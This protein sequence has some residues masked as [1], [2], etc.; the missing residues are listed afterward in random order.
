MHASRRIFMGLAG[1]LGLVG[2][3]T[4]GLTAAASPARGFPAGEKPW[5]LSRSESFTLKWRDREFLI[6][7]ARPNDVDPDLPL[8]LGGYKPVPVYVTDGNEN[9]PIVAAIT[10]QMQWGGEVPPCLV[11][12]VDY[13]DSERAY[14]EDWRTREL[15]PTKDPRGLPRDAHGEFGGA[16][17]FRRFLVETLRPMIERRF[18]V[19][20]SRS[21]LVGHSFGGLFTLDTMLEEPAAFGNYLAMSP[22][23]WFDDNVV[24][25]S[26]KQ[27][28]EAGTV[29]A[30]RAAVFAGE[31]EERISSP[32]THM[33]S[34][35]LEFG[36]LVADHRRSF[37]GGALVSVLP[38]TTHHT[39]VGAAAT[40]GMRYLVAPEE[41][42]SETF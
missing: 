22:S 24:L 2:R 13:L 39:I 28:V 16:A 27:K 37:P 38:G 7:I 29:F 40:R 11:V 20:R 26:F 32:E 12:G 42:R 25:R 5:P 33:T 17:E 41:R 36:R 18:D 19:D 9:F 14:K 30:S 23:L 6:G 35:T 1:A 31:Q 34:N 8:M 3:E 4:A 15:T 10:R 21:T